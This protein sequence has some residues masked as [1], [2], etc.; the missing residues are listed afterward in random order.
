[1]VDGAAF[2][3]G[4]VDGQRHTMGLERLAIGAA[5]AIGLAAHRV[6]EVAIFAPDRIA[7]RMLYRPAGADIN[8]DV[9]CGQFESQIFAEDMEADAVAP[10]EEAGGGKI[11][12]RA[13]GETQACRTGRRDIEARE[14]LAVPVPGE[15]KNLGHVAGK[16]A[17]QIDD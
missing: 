9:M 16:I 15:S 10:I 13:I 4:L 1:N 2:A 7:L 11:A 3:G 14:L 5:N 12:D 17:C 8:H 6:D